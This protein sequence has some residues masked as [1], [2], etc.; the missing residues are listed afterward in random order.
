MIL[1]A[2]QLLDLSE[3]VAGVGMRSKILLQALQNMVDLKR[4]SNCYV[5]S[6]N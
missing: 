6:A 2:I 4:I 5:L 3:I 1:V